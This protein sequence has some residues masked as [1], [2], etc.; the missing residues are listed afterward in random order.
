VITP[1]LGYTV[2]GGYPVSGGALV[3]LILNMLEGYDLTSLGNFT[4]SS[5]SAHWLIEAFKFAYSDQRLLGDPS[6]SDLENDI[7][8][9]N[10]KLHAAELRSRLDPDKTFDP[11]FYVDLT[12]SPIQS[13]DKGTAH[14]SVVD[15]DRNACSFT[16]TVID[17]WGARVVSPRTGIIVNDLM[18]TFTD[19]DEDNPWRLPVSPANF[20]EPHKFPNANMS[21]TI[22][23]KDNK[24][25]MV[26]GC[27]G[28]RKIQTSI[29]QILIHVLGFK[30]TLPQAVYSKRIHHQL[31]PNELLLEEGYPLNI[32][33]EL[34]IKGHDV[35]WESIMTSYIHAIVQ[36]ENGQLTAVADPR[37]DIMSIPAGY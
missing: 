35:H 15:K 19:P 7:Q 5:Q 2:Y 12:E 11:S 16:D 25:Y 4:A 3:A 9:M 23:L 37:A 18:C 17:A 22:V 32:A 33:A 20:V 31:I 34:A 14:I 29:S 8:T 30:S 21:P 10:D 27:A 6:F 36:E 1:F 28:S 26:I 24:F 13:F